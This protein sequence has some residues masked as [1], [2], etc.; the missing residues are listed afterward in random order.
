LPLSAQLAEGQNKFLGNIIAGSVPSSF[1]TYWNQVTPENSGK[2]GSVESSRDSMN[3]SGLD[4]AYNFAKNNGYPFKQHTFVWGSQEPGWIGSLSQTEQRA[5]VEE[6]I[7]AYCDRYPDTDLIDVVNEPLHTPASYRN[8]LGGAGSTGW[9]WVVTAFQM[10]RQHCPNAQ[11]LINDYGITNDSNATG[12]Y[13]QIIQILQDRGLLDGIGDQV[14]TFNI[15]GYS[16]STLQSNLDRLTATGLPVYVSEWDV[17]SSNDQTQL[18][19]YQQ[20]F[21]IYW[22]N[23]GVKGMTL[24]GYIQ[25]TTW[26]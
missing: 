8:A 6:W 5:E 20:K 7:G 16:A 15:I 18:Q 25:G 17:N 23:P 19:E 12:Q 11:L 21:P 2:W 3:W 14:H 22:D 13:L 4:M 26:Q 1:S 9:D 24:W 10:A